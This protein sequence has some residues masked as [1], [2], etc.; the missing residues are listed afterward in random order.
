MQ[1]L[2]IH[3]GQ[4]GQ[5]ACIDAIA[6]GMFFE[7]LAQVRHLLAVHQIDCDP[8][9]D[10]EDGHRKPGHASGFH[11]GLDLLIRVVRLGHFQQSSQ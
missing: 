3:E 10:Q 4:F 8:I 7:V 6:L 5:H 9:P 11:H 2:C 1:F